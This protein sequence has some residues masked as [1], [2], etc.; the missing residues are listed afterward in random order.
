MPAR[1]QEHSQAMWTVAP[2]G[3]SLDGK[4]NRGGNGCEGSTLRLPQ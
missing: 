4:G 2:E 1:G 3:K